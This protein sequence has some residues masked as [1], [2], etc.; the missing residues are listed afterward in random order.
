[1]WS[2]LLAAAISSTGVE[3]MAEE[4]A[5][6]MVAA[7]GQQQQQ[8]QQQQPPPPPLRPSLGEA[9][10]LRLAEV[11]KDEGLLGKA[12][13][14]ARAF[15]YSREGGG[16][17]KA[18][19]EELAAQ[20]KDVELYASLK[21]ELELSQCS[22]VPHVPPRAVTMAGGGGALK[23]PTPATIWEQVKAEVAG[24]AAHL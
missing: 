12:V 3:N 6:A 8:Q 4:I 2:K 21:A 16:K 19:W 5:Y 11:V 23:H 15:F 10:S 14:A 17:Q 22:F 24:S 13:E 18:I 1:M 7:G 20:K 9:T